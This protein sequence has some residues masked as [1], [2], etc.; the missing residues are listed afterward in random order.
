MNR[1]IYILIVVFAFSQSLFAQSMSEE[2]I[3]DEVYQVV[4]GIQSIQCDFTQT[5]SVKMLAEK[6]VSYGS[7]AYQHDKKLRWEYKEPFSHIFILNETQVKIQDKAS[8]E[9]IDVEKSRIFKEVV[10][11]IKGDVVGQSFKDGK[12]FAVSCSIVKNEYVAILTTQNQKLKNMFAGLTL[13]IDKDKKVL[14]EIEISSAKGDKTVLSFQN[15]VVNA[16]VDD[17]LFNI[18]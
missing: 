4:K 13:H 16:T 15:V 17:S 18:N 9:T 2:Q 5:K 14:T 7:M 10:K 8:T 6:A 12:T 3:K 1:L 11:M